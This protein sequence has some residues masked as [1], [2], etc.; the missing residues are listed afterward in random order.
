MEMIREGY[1]TRLVVGKND[2]AT[3]K[4]ELLKDW[5]YEKNGNLLPNQVAF[6]SSKTKV[7]WKC[8][9]C[10][11]E[12]QS[13]PNSRKLC[14]AC[15]SHVVA[16]GINDLATT[17]PHLLKDWDYEKNKDV[18]PTQVSHGSHRKVW[19]KC[20]KGHE[21]EASINDKVGKKHCPFCSHKRVLPGFNDLATTHPEIAKEWNYE[22]NNGILPTQVICGNNHK[23]WF[24]CEKGHEWQAVLSSR[25]VCGCPICSGHKVL[26]GY[27]DLATVN[28]ELAKEWNYEKN[29]NLLPTMVTI[30]SGKKVWWKCKH[31]HEWQSPPYNRKKN[32]GCPYCANQKLLKGFNDLETLHPEL[33][34]EWHPTKNGNLKPSDVISGVNKKAWWQ[35]KYGHEWEAVIS[36]RIHGRNC[37]VCAGQKLLAGFNDLAT[38]APEELKDWNYEKNGDL[39]PS[40][41]MSCTDKKVWWKCHI[42]GHEWLG[43][44]CSK[45]YA[46]GVGCPRCNIVYGTSFAEQAIFYYLKKCLGKKEDIVNRYKFVDDDYSFEIDVFLPMMAV[47]IEHDGEYWHRQIDRI[48]FDKLKEKHL[49]SLGIRL[50]RVKEDLTNKVEGDVIYY[51]RHKDLSFAIRTLFELLHLNCSK[52]DFSVENYR[53]E[54]LRDCLI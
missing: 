9:K 29:G 12:W 10:G 36:S 42:C 16:T 8:H 34:K 49:S 46:K 7:W 15:A 39:L 6:G 32:V 13:S 5:D 41:V 35:C 47:A 37:P 1:M 25:K 43:A 14:P 45:R 23:F 20:E 38:V 27:N 22:R 4:P 50:I 51:N 44:I 30:S 19:W 18:L 31:G 33:A 26:V 17:H 24:K 21:W 11:Y 40:M 54:I 2:L 52:V 48:K 3:V 53:K 28:P